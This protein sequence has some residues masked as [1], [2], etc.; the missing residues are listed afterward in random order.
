M[1]FP[2]I[3]A[4]VVVGAALGATP[5]L[6]SQQPEKSGRITPAATI[7]L[8]AGSGQNTFNVYLSDLGEL[9]Q[10]VSPAGTSNV[11]NHEFYLCNSGGF[12]ESA[13]GFSPWSVYQPKGPNKLPLTITIR[14]DDG[15]W[16]V[17]QSYARDLKQ[18]ELTTTYTLRRLAAATSSVLFTQYL[19]LEVDGTSD[20]DVADKSVDAVTARDVHMFSWT[21]LT[22]TTAHRTAIGYYY[23]LRTCDP[24]SEA[25]PFGPED[26]A[27]AVTYD[28]GGFA[29]GQSK[30]VKL[31]LE[32]Q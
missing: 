31:K 5:T 32:R 11:F 28:L 29:S 26:T 6:S 8:T 15:A 24:A 12:Y 14:T 1:T 9:L 20:D 19:D 18:L 7:S 4:T 21:A 27:F 13:G 30:S 2:R 22:R 17:S 16:E 10:L 3:V 25:G 23:D